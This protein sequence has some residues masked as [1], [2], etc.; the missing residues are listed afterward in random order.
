[1]ES[2][3]A[4]SPLEPPDTPPRR[5]DSFERIAYSPL[6]QQLHYLQTPFSNIFFSHLWSIRN[7]H[8]HFS[9]PRMLHCLPLTSEPSFIPSLPCTVPRH[10]SSLPLALCA[11]L[12]L[13]S[14]LHPLL[15][16]LSLPPSFPHFP[17]S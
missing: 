3:Q 8:I 17:S 12:C 10:Y 16:D 11:S 7:S 13:A 14:L 1:M 5:L 6:F 9:S 15:K 2:H 4:Y